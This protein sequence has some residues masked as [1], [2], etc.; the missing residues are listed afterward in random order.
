MN[1]YRCRDG[2]QRKLY[3]NLERTHEQRNVEVFGIPSFAWMG[4]EFHY[5]VKAF[6]NAGQ[7][8]ISDHYLGDYYADMLEDLDDLAL[9]ETCVKHIGFPWF[10]KTLSFYLDID[11]ESYLQRHESREHLLPENTEVAKQNFV[12]EEL[13]NARRERYHRLVDANLLTLID[14][15]K[16]VDTVYLEVKKVVLHAKTRYK[17]HLDNDA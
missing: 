13:F 14:A 10:T 2:F 16:D 1:L 4:L 11:Y 5:R 12:P 9:L 8:V 3:D 17:K 15:R 6:L 7:P